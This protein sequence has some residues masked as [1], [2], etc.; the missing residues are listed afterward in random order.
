MD[1][2][3]ITFI[4]LALSLIA[5]ACTSSSQ[6]ESDSQEAA[7]T[8]LVLNENYVDTLLL[9]PTSFDKQVR[10][11]GRLRAKAKSILVMPTSGVLTSI[12]VRNGSIVEKGQLLAC[13]DE[14]TAQQDLE[15]AEQDLENAYINLVDKL[16]GQGYDENFDQIPEDLL[17]RTQISSGYLTAEHRL[18]KARIQKEKCRLYAPFSGRVA[19]IGTKLFERTDKFCTL[20]DDSFFDVEFTVLESELP[21]LKEVD[22]VLVFPF[23]DETKRFVGKISEINP[24]VDENGQIAVKVTIRNK[25]NTLIEGMNARVIL[26]SR[27]NNLY[28]VPKD[29]V[30]TRDGYPVVFKYEKGAAVWTYVDILHSN[31]HSHAIVGNRQKNSTLSKGDIIITSGNL[32]LANGTPVKPRMK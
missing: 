12:H 17:R 21:F 19:D 5:V 25:D 3:V 10:S 20:I 22:Q 7:L 24:I 4:S 32:N 8:K 2:K 11:N 1:A 26:Q 30:V 27:I 14:E 13:V 28:V 15:Q 9:T 6:T 18:K 29:A 23:V 31:I 16:I